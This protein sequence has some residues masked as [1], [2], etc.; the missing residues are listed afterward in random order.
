MK[1]EASPGAFGY[2][3]N[4]RK[5]R[6][7][8][9][10]FLF[11]VA[12]PAVFIVVQAFQ[13]IKWEAFHQYQALAIEFSSRVDENIAELIKTEESRT[14]GDYNFTIVMGS[15]SNNFVQRSPLSNTV[16]SSFPGFIGYFQIDPNNNLSSPLL[17][18]NKSQAMRY[19]L[20]EE[21]VRDREAAKDKLRGIFEQ[22]NVVLQQPLAD[23]FEQLATKKTRKSKS[24]E[25]YDLDLRYQRQL[26]D[27][28][29]SESAG[30]SDAVGAAEEASQAVESRS[31]GRLFDSSLFRSE[32]E[33]LVEKEVP[34]PKPSS[35][36]PVYSLFESQ[37]SPFNS[38][39]LES[40]HLMFY[41][42][43]WQENQRFVQ[44]FILNRELLVK[45]MIADIYRD[46]SLSAVSS[47]A[48]VWNNQIK[49][50]FSPGYQRE[51]YLR[52]NAFSGDLSGTLLHRYRL[53][54]PVEEWELLFT[55]ETLPTGTSGQVLILSGTTFILV[56]FVG[57]WLI[58]RLLVKQLRL[59]AQQQNFV[60][61]ISHELKTPLTSI[62]M[63]G[64]ILREGWAKEDKQK[65]YYD[66]IFYESERLGRLINNVLQLAKMTRSDIPMDLKSVTFSKLI[67]LVRSTIVSQVERA[68]FNL[69]IECSEK[70]ANT[71]I[72]LDVDLFL[73]IIINLVDN[74]LKFS[75]NA[76]L[77]QVRLEFSRDRQGRPRIAVRDFGPGVEK[78]Q[79]QKIFTLFYRAENELTRETTGTG[80]GLALVFQLVQAMNGKIHV[81]NKKPG[82][83]FSIEFLQI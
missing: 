16:E 8:T 63:Y 24:V 80:I 62:K 65:E 33:L 50:V 79:L 47:L 82:V 2:A 49:E 27:S 59:S 38:T 69:V 53:S 9:L 77:K 32:R 52:S 7:F 6:I 54:S 20:S 66:Y 58:Y 23:V 22:N 28:R 56:L 44:G 31:A 36:E 39:M 34:A 10:L 15:A 76:E 78:S 17:P 41:R 35:P 83:E 26:A 4:L 30:K 21:Q 25:E 43:V 67:D 72:E 51:S 73:Q 11:A 74:A 3:R 12:S 57:C 61:S 14:F 48:M 29:V 81:E 19:G 40:G 55:I 71:E 18:E 45:S 37:I 13:Q 68:G 5:I 70:N 1:V 46:T 75:R 64:E 42:F 60:S